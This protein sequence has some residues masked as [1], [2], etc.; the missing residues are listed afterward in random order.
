MRL[1]LR[2]QAVVFGRGA[3]ST[4]SR[5]QPRSALVTSSAGR[6]ASPRSASTRAPASPRRRSA[7]PSPTLAVTAVL[8]VFNSQANTD[9][10]RRVAKFTEALFARI[11]KFQKKPRHPKWAEVNLA[12]TLPGWQRFGA[13]QEILDR[14]KTAAAAGAVDDGAKLKQAFDAFLAS[15]PPQE[16]QTLT[17]K[18]REEMFAKFMEWRA[19][20][21]QP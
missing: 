6:R 4:M 10:Y 17:P 11:D 3:A 12:A 7:S 16:T 2:Q 20:Q 19:A 13:A 21:K 18:R 5:G 14:R 15:L 9:R 8:A 1:A